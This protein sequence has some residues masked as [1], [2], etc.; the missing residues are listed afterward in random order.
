[1]NWKLF[2]KLTVCKLL[3][4]IKASNAMNEKE[5]DSIEIVI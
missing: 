4:F 1:M 5:I 2:S 3:Q